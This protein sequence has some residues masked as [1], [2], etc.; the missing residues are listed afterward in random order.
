MSIHKDYKRA[1]SEVA[2]PSQASDAAPEAREVCAF[3][4]PMRCPRCRGLLAREID[5]WFCSD[6]G[7]FPVRQGI[8]CFEPDIFSH[9]EEHWAGMADEPL[10]EPKIDVGRRFLDP[11]RDTETEGKLVLDVGCGD[12]IHAVALDRIAGHAVRYV[13]LDLSWSA[14]RRAQRTAGVAGALVQ[15]SAQRMPF[16]DGCFDIVFAYGLLGYTPDPAKAFAEMCRVAKGDGL[17]GLWLYPP[18]TGLAGAIFRLTRWLCRL[19]GSPG[20][21]FLSNALV[22]LLPMLPT[23]SGVSLRNASWRQCREVIAVNI[24]PQ[25]TFVSE[26]EIARWFTARG[27]KLVA[28][29][30]AMPVTAW[31]RK[32]L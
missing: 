22:P 31:G 19:G 21:W 24:V 18:P 8:P 11:L 26:A 28:T 20:A 7:R 32:P 16:A 13:G 29:E 25:L 5:A 15:G 23:S 1:R 17:V 6:H 27:L 30:A 9:F 4:I 3:D 12:G 10:P 2:I 14:L